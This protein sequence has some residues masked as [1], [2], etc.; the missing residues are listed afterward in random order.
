MLHLNNRVNSCVNIIGRSAQIL[1][2]RLLWIFWWV[3]G[4]FRETVGW[5]KPVI[6]L[7]G[8]LWRSNIVDALGDTPLNTFL[9]ILAITCVSTPLLSS[10]YSRRQFCE[11]SSEH[12]C[13]YFCECASLYSC[14]CS[15][16]CS[17]QYI[18]PYSRERF[19]QHKAGV[20]GG[21]IVNNMVS[22][23]WARVWIPSKIGLSSQVIICLVFR[24]PHSGLHPI[25]GLL[26]ALVCIVLSWQHEKTNLP[27][28]IYYLRPTT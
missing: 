4:Y 10:W 24:C 5:K 2:C 7:W 3:F 14:E 19:T 16:E 27:P 12:P 9:E 23:C 1:M 20:V 25:V 26:L 6:M 18:S 28:T 15:G 8:S 11:L 21:A 13:G 22:F 17:C